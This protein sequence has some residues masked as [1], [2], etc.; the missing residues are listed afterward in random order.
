MKNPLIPF[1]IIAAFGIVLIFGLSIKGI[2]DSQDIASENTD[3]EVVVAFDGEKTYKQACIACHGENYEG[4]VGPALIGVG[5]RLSTDEIKN[6]LVNGQG[7]MP[8]GLVKGDDAVKMAE[9]LV[10]LK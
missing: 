1:A 3:G 5:D 4:V 9:W 6:I 10:T 7:N 8:A 2:Q